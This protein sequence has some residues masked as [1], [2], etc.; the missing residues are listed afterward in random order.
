M[1]LVILD[2]NWDNVLIVDNI[3]EDI[4]DVVD[5]VNKKL[6]FEDSDVCWML[7]DKVNTIHYIWD[8][9]LNKMIP[10]SIKQ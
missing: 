1:K 4:D 9:S 3:P 5:F 2:Y 7:V 10:K 8:E 6:G